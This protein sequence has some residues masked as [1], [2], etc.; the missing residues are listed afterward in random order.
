MLLDRKVNLEVVTIVQAWVQ[1]ITCAIKHAILRRKLSLIK[2]RQHVANKVKNPLI[3]RAMMPM[4]AH[5]HLL[6]IAFCFMHNVQEWARKCVELN[7]MK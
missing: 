4:C 6:M 5:L 7:L 3:V 2:V 1:I